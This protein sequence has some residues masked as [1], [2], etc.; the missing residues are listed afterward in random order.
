MSRGKASR[1]QESLE[2]ILFNPHVGVV[3]PSA[4]H[5]HAKTTTAGVATIEMEGGGRNAR[6]AI[7]E[8]IDSREKPAV[9]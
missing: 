9:M 4:R 8:Q 3:A 2:W 1:V 7:V 5:E 6:I